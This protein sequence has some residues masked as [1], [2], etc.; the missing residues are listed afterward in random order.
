MPWRVFGQFKVCCVTVGLCPRGNHRCGSFVCV[1]DPEREL[2][3]YNSYIKVWSSVCCCPIPSP[4][5]VPPPLPIHC[6][7]IP[8]AAVHQKCGSGHREQVRGCGSSVSRD[9]T[10]VSM[11]DPVRDRT[12]AWVRVQ[13]A[14]RVGNWV[15]EIGSR[16][17]EG[18]TARGEREQAPVG[19]GGGRQAAGEEN[20]RVRLLTL[21]RLGTNLEW[22]STN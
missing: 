6:C 16:D 21:L 11:G 14:A 3:I 19:A 20:A 15:E 17:A 2:C 1:P 7:L 18:V 12:A 22:S 10:V 4:V 5:L 9:G 8:S 13:A